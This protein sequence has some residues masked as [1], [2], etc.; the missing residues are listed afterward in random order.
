[1]VT[2]YYL[3]RYLGFLIGFYGNTDFDSLEIGTELERFLSDVH[4]TFKQ[5]SVQLTTEIS[6]KDRK[7]ITDSLGKAGDRYRSLVYY[8]FSG[9]KS[10]ISRAEILDF[11]RISLEFIN[12]S[13]RL[14]KRADGLYHAY[15]LIE[16][17]DSGYGIMHL[18]PML[19][20]QVAVLSSGFTSPDESLQLL[21]ALRQSDLYVKDQNS[22]I[23]YP[24]K[25]LPLFLDKSRIAPESVENSKLLR[26]LIAEQDNSIILK[27]ANG[28]YYFHPSLCNANDL[29]NA[30]QNLG[31]SEYMSLVEEESDSV[32]TIYE[33]IFHH[34]LFTGRSGSFFGYEG[35]GSIYWHMNSK[36]VLAVQ[37]IY[38]ASLE[39]ESNEQLI[40]GLKKQYFEM[41]EGLGTHKTP[42]NYGAFPIDPYSH[43]PAHKGA[44]QPG[45]TGQVKE[46]IISRMGEL[47]LQIK[48][49]RISI[50]P[51]L[52]KS[53]EFID[54]E[55]DLVNF[56][57]ADLRISH[58]LVFT[59]CGTP[60]VY[61]KT[62]SSEKI[63]IS[64]TNGKQSEVEGLELTIEESRKIFTRDKSIA[65]LRVLIPG[66]E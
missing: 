35:L 14:N 28:D 62:T 3:R 11:L 45:M 37:E 4:G 57:L 60:F 48:E 63:I 56:G 18:Y 46:D 13:I 24:D 12:E 20:G 10:E 26:K 54:S 17:K 65:Y 21:D 31:G 64:Y 66:M 42:A 38:Y 1:M 32:L 29:R 44:Q 41:K 25:Q 53:S 33:Q 47:G 55:H 52:L 8:D 15:N 23:L 40:S 30:L 61:S 7:L 59:F 36:L 22:Y 51:S 50:N 49:G 19:E 34:H 5:Y 6:D 9:G 43:T 2:V 58:F 16:I 39:Q 27:G